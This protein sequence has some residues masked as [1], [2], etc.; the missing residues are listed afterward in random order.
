MAE[1]DAAVHAARALLHSVCPETA[2]RPRASR[3]CAPRPGASVLLALDLDESCRLT[4]GAQPPTRRARRTPAT[5]TRCRDELRL[6]ARLAP[7]AA[8]HALVVARHHL[9]ELRCS[10][11]QSARMRSRIAAAR[12][13]STCFMIA[14]RTKS[15][16]SA[17]MSGSRSTMSRL[18]RLREVAVAIEHVRDAAAHA[19]GE[20]AA[21]SGR[22]RR[23]GRRSCI[24]SRGRRRL[25]RPT[26]AP[27]LRTQ[28]RS[29]AT[30][31]TYA[32]PLVAP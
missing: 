22:A 26:C 24:R 28:N 1:R 16:S 30:P 2:D 17:S 11:A 23:R 19:G 10:V 27:L 31:R 12:S 21:R 15:M 32:S 7:A 18:Q 4:H 20:V 14:T 9:D 3:G 29:P 25:R 8:Q 5:P 13:A 6:A